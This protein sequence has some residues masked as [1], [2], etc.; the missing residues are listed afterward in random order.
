MAFGLPISYLLTSRGSAPF[1]FL[2]YFCIN[3]SLLGVNY[4]LGHYGFTYVVINVINVLER[5]QRFA[6]QRLQRFE[7][8]R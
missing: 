3:A 5:L 2:V 1:T 7:L 8:Q 4:A 6:L